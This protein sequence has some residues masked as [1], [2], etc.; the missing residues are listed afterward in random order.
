VGCAAGAALSGVFLALREICCSDKDYR[1]SWDTSKNRK[2]F[3][4]TNIF[5][6]QSSLSDVQTPH[7]D[8]TTDGEQ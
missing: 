1:D 5:L 7:P 4:F 2:V 8:D 3:A 6:S